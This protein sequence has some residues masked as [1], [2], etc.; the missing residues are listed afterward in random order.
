VADPSAASAS[1]SS[2]APATA[3]P[4]PPSAT[5]IVHRPEPGIARG[6]WE[7]PTWAF[8]VAGAVAVLFALVYLGARIGLFERAKK[9]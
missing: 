7:A 4:A 3:A 5:E 8:Y 6:R 1:A 2:A 9:S